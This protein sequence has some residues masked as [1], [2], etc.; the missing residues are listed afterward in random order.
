MYCET[1]DSYREVFQ[2]DPH[3]EVWKLPEEELNLKI[4]KFYDVNLIRL[5][6]DFVKIFFTPIDADK[7]TIN[8]NV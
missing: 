1:L 5:E 8:S 7:D 4:T 2:H 3:P 6:I